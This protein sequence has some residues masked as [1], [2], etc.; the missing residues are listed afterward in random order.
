MKK[1]MK[2]LALVLAATMLFTGCG[3][4][5]ATNETV[6]ETA[7]AENEVVTRGEYNIPD[8]VT[9]TDYK[10]IKLSKDA[11]TATD[12]E[13]QEQIDTLIEYGVS[14]KSVTRAAKSGDIVNIDYEGSMDGETF[15]GGT[16]TGYDLELGSGTFIDGFEDGLIG[17]KAGETVT[18][19][20]KFPDDYSVDTTKA[21]KDVDFKVTVN[22]VKKKVTPEYNDELVQDQTD[23]NTTDEFE[24][25]AKADIEDTKM[26]NAMNSAIL[27]MAQ[28]ADELP[29]SLVAFYQN[30][31]YEYYDSMFSTYYGMTLEQYME[32][33]GMTLDDF[34]ANAGVETT[35][36]NELV[37]KCIADQEGIV[38]EGEEYESYLSE[39]AEKYGID[40]ET[41]LEQMT[42]D[43]AMYLY[44]IAK[45]Q[46]VVS[47]NAVIE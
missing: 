24:A 33:A 29:E 31:Y 26:T 35:V 5:S 2:G 1:C 10:G 13:I 15:D 20:L 37:W 32:S 41:Y 6:A 28:F 38:A 30:R 3:S 39:Q 43:E 44:T 40:V 9:I 22:E 45:A 25:A 21:G 7:A 42:E 47:T 34:Y 19:N 17:V 36:K 16:S 11:V 23:Y 8:Y 27:E 18:L 14:E 4:T 12:D 46:E